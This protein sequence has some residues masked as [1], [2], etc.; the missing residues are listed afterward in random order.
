[1][2]GFLKAMVTAPSLRNVISFVFA[3]PYL[4]RNSSTLL[5]RD[6]SFLY[7]SLFSKVYFFAEAVRS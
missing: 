1:M 3:L 5:I 6:C 2:A 7:D 4:E